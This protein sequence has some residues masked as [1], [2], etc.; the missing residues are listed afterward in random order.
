M[1]L[2]LGLLTKSPLR[3]LRLISTTLMF[4]EFYSLF[5]AFA[6]DDQFV[7][8]GLFDDLLL[9]NYEHFGSL[10]PVNLCC[11]GLPDQRNIYLTN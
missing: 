9:G 7:E 5:V 6:V 4:C 3:F 2:L 8:L 11:Y 1:S 10:E